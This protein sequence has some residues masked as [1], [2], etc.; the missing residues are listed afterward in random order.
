MPPPILSAGGDYSTCMMPNNIPPGTKVTKGDL[1]LFRYERQSLSVFCSS[2]L[3]SSV[4]TYDDWRRGPEKQSHRGLCPFAF[5]DF[6]M[7][8]ASNREELNG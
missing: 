1:E 6:L 7:L 5:L 8:V 2:G 4:Y 3:F